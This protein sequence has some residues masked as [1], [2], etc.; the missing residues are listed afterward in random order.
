MKIIICETRTCSTVNI[1]KY[2]SL[3][4][5]KY[6]NKRTLKTDLFFNVLL[7]KITCDKKLLLPNFVLIKVYYKVTQVRIKI[8]FNNVAYKFIL[9]LISNDCVKDWFQVFKGMKANPL[10]IAVTG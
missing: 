5:D 6:C 4:F 10:V 3:D 2:I 7:M 1:T 9:E 8:T